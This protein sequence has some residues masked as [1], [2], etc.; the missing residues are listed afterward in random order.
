MQSMTMDHRIHPLFRS[1]PTANFRCT[2][3]YLDEIVRQLASRLQGH[4]DYWLSPVGG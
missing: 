3:L 2:F 4:W 1:E